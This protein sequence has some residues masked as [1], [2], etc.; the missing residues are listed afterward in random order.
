MRAR[1]WG[2]VGPVLC[3]N[4]YKFLARGGFGAQFASGRP[5]PG[6]SPAHARQL[7]TGLGPSWYVASADAQLSAWTGAIATERSTLI[8]APMR[9]CT[10]LHVEF[11]LQVLP[12]QAR[13][14][15]R[16]RARLPAR[17]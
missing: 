12:R 6:S 5:Q 7:S 3:W 17:V 16:W 9:P 1:I 15:Q 8:T 2:S 13:P 11:G 10:A 4:K 14:G